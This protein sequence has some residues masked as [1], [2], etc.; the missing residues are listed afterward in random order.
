MASGGDVGRYS[1]TH[2]W[3]PHHRNNYFEQSDEVLALESIYGENEMGLN[4]LS[5]PETEADNEPKNGLYS[6]QM[7][8]PID[9]SDERVTVDVCVPLNELQNNVDFSKFKRSDSGMRIIGS[10]TVR[11]LYPISLTIVLPHEYPSSAPPKFTISCPWLTSLQMTSLCQAMDRLWEESMYMPVL[12]TWITW[13]QENVMNH[14]GLRNRIFLQDDLDEGDSRVISEQMPI[15]EA[16]TSMI[17]YDQQREEEEFAQSEQE[18]GICFTQQAGS[19]FLRL[20]PCKHHFCRI[21]VNEYCRTYIKE[22]NVLNLICPETD[23]KSEIPPPM[24]TANLTPEEYE[25]YETL[26]LRKGLDC[27]GDI[28]WCPRCQNPVI[29]EKEEALRLGHCLDC[30]YSFCTDCQEP[31]HQGRCY[32]DVLQEEEDEKLRQTKSEAMQK[33]RERLARLKEE[34]LSREIIEKTTRPCPNCKMD[35]SKMSGCNKV[36]CVYCNHS[37]CWGCGLDITKESYGHFSKCSLSVMHEEIIDAGNIYN[38]GGVNYVIRPFARAHQKEK[39]P[40]VVEIE[41]A[42]AANPDEKINLIRCPFC[43]Q[44]N[45]RKNQ[46]NHIRCWNCTRSTCFQCKKAIS[47]NPITK[48][49]STPNLC[50]QHSS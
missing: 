40:I 5:R 47:E 48:H 35:I 9:T 43:K 34:R 46:D 30:V 22:G 16:F 27:M 49:F 24:V 18:C 12:F 6:V 44:K 36:S 1:Q 33:K 32:S 21:C 10:V 15:E 28:V 19:L 23:C 14:L 45:L 7:S 4:I 42:L 11:H 8:V 41:V 39:N 25:R 50:K 38:D 17:R 3:A 13:L 31:W 29:Q 37:M 2:T 20:R 26:S